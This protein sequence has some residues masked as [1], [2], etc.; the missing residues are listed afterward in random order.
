[1]KLG[2]LVEKIFYYTGIKWLHKKI[3]F[4]ILKY[5]SCG[6]NDRKEKLN[7]LKINR[8]G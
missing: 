2:D 5:E 3:W 7:N 1:M 4:D 8:N 6:C